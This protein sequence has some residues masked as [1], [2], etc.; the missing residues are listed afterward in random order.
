MLASQIRNRLEKFNFHQRSV[1]TNHC[2]LRELTD[3]TDVFQ[4]E[5]T[6][7]TRTSIQWFGGHFVAAGPGKLTTVKH[8]G[9]YRVSEGVILEHVR[10]SVKIITAKLELSR[11]QSY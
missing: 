5:H 7:K 4:K 11:S 1:R 8:H 9:C 6:G 2:S 3:Q 10:P